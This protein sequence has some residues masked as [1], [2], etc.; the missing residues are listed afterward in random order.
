SPVA[1]EAAAALEA[2]RG[3]ATA[4]GEVATVPYAPADLVALARRGLRADVLRQVT[5]GRSVVEQRLGRVPSVNALVPPKFSLDSRAAAT[6]GPVG[7]AGAL[8]EAGR[9][10]EVRDSDVRPDLFGPSQ[11]VLIRAADP[12]GALI[13]DQP[14]LERLAATDQGVLLGQAVVAETASAWLELPVLAPER[15]I[16]IASHALPS[17]TTLAAALD[18][19]SGAPWVQLRT[20]GDAIG[21]LNKQTIPVSLRPGEAADRPYLREA[22]RARRALQTVTSIAVSP[23]DE[24]ER[25]NRLILVAESAEWD[26]AEKQGVAL[27]A[28]VEQRSR[29]ILRSVEVFSR[30]VTLT[31]RTGKVPVT[32]INGNAFPV[33]VRVRLQSPKVG[34]PQGATRTVEVAAGDSSIDFTV[35][36]RAAGSFP[37]TVRVETP[38]GDRLLAS[39]TLTLRSTTVSAVAL[40]AVGGSTLFLL[41]AWVRR[42]T[43]RRK[44][45]AHG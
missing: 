16:T 9:L 12:Y 37:L 33:R 5:L 4:V 42:G 35:E 29:A 43:R 1:L 28:A 30:P 10:P 2:A 21:T 20:V 13:P 7:I 27:A 6:L 31:A 26:T 32:V 34:F 3:A 22:R 19:L 38:D 11:P 18:G 15:V 36:A 39:G 41:A 25:L 17:P 8:I 23:P 24:L 44:R 40:A 14:L 45:A